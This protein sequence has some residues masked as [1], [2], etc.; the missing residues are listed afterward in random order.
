MFK[1]EYPNKDKYDAMMIDIGTRMFD[2]Q[3]M[4]AKFVAEMLDE[5]GD[6]IPV[7][8]EVPFFSGS[9][10]VKISIKKIFFDHDDI[11]IKL[12]QADTG[13]IL[14]WRDLPVSSQELLASQMHMDYATGRIHDSFENKNDLH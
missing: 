10:V 12:E 4:L 9:D 14:S 7:D 3:I 5:F 6:S 11:E 8:S 1:N 13:N 2:I